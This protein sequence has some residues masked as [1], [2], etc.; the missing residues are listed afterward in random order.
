[1]VIQ[2]KK[3]A[4][5]LEIEKKKEEN[6]LYMK[7][8][9]VFSGIVLIFLVVIIACGI[10]AFK[11][12]SIGAAAGVFIGSFVL[13]CIMMAV[14]MRIMGIIS[15]KIMIQMIQTGFKGL[16]L[17]GKDNKDDGTDTGVSSK[18]E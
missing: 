7:K 2:R 6:K 11:Y 9:Q 15:P 8:V 17:F 3:K 12:L 10:F 16:K 18:S 14:I 4:Q 5:E 13:L 1:L